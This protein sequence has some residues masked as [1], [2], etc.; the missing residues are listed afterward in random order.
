VGE[1]PVLYVADSQKQTW[2]EPIAKLLANGEKSYPDEY[3]NAYDAFSASRVC[4][5]ETNKGGGL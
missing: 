2:E 4:I 5:P 3:D 1:I